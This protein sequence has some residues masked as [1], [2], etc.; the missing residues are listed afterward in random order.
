MF[1]EV[2]KS[3]TIQMEMDTKAICVTALIQVLSDKALRLTTFA[4][5]KF[6]L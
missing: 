4:M 3:R 5:V 6:N 2:L 1:A